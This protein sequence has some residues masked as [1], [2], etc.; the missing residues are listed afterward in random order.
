MTRNFLTKTVPA[1]T[2][3]TKTIPK[4]FNEK[5]VILKIE[6]LYILFTFLIFI[7][8]LLIIFN[9]YCCLIKHLLWHQSENKLKMSDKLK[10]IDMKNRTYCFFNDL[11]KVKSRQMKSH[12]K[13]FSFTTLDT[14]RSLHWIRE[15]QRP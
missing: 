7:I 3:S 4:N 9:V 12:T 15:T 10:E 2:V 11:I 8:S 1:K 13:T 6:N 5:K 14:W